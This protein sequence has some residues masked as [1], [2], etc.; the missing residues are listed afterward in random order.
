LKKKKK[1]YNSADQ[2]ALNGTDRVR[3]DSSHFFL[4]QKKK[5][6]CKWGSYERPASVVNLLHGIFKNG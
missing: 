3:K 6:A 1:M 4:G 2:L 5:K